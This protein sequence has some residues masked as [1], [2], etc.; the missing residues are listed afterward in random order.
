[1]HYI[2]TQRHAVI[3]SRAPCRP[4]VPTAVRQT[5]VHCPSARRHMVQMHLYMLPK[6]SQEDFI[7]MQLKVRFTCADDKVTL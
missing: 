4:C 6:S 5:S 2:H 7:T 1:M 3:D